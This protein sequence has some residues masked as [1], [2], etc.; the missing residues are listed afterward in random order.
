MPKQTPREGLADLL[1]A[2]AN[3]DSVELGAF[4]GNGGGEATEADEQA[5]I[6]RDLADGLRVPA[7]A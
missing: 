7:V 2:L 5:M 3:G 1:D 4:G 6:L